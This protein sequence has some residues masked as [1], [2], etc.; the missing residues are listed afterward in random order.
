MKKT[1]SINIGGVIFHIEEDGYEKLKSYL[2]SIQRYFATFSD[3][4]EI[5]SDIEAR[6]AERFYNKQ[7][8]EVKQVISI[9]DVEELIKA[10]GTVADFEAIEQA[11]DILADPLEV[12]AEPTYEP[13]KKEKL[14][15]T[16]ETASEERAR[17]KSNIPRKLYRDLKRKLIGGVAAGLANYF[18]IDAIWVRLAFIIAVAGLPASGMLNLNME[19]AFGPISGFVTLLY[20]AMWIAFP[21]S[22]T[23]EED[24]TIK[25]FYRDPD[26]KVVGGVAAGIASYFGI[27]LGVARFLWVISILFF[28]TGFVAYVVLWVISPTAN[29]L[30]EKMEMQGEPITLSNIESNIKQSLNLDSVPGEENWVSKIMLF[31]FRAIAFIITLLGKLL[32][33]IG[34]VIRVIIG[35]VLVGFSAL[36]LLGIIIAGG[37]A[38]GLTS[39]APFD[40]LP[41]PFLIFQ[42]LPGSLILSAILL[43]SIPLLLFLLLGITLLSNRKVV[44]TSVWL[45][46]AGL[47]IVG[48]IGSII[49]GVTYQRNFAKHGE[50]VVTTGFSI[51]KGTL[52]LETENYSND[53]NSVDV[54]IRLAG[55]EASDSLK[56]EKKL[57]SRGRSQEDAERNAQKLQYKLNIKDSVLTF[58]TDPE[59]SKFSF[60][61]NQRIDA[62]LNIPYNKPFIMSRDFYFASS[63]WGDGYQNIGRYDLDNNDINWKSLRWVMLRDSGLICANMPQRFLKT[64]SN[65]DENAAAYRYDDDNGDHLELGDRGNYIKQFPV[66]AFSKIDLGGAYAIH[67]QYGEVYEVT[68]DGEEEDVNNIRVVNENGILKVERQDIG[69]FDDKKWNRIGLIIKTPNL[70][71]IEL[72]GAN[73]TKVSGFKGLGRLEV[74][75]SGSSRSEIEVEA[76]KLDIDISGASKAMFRGTAKDVK[77]YL[78]GASKVEARAMQI[79]RAE[80]SAAGASYADMG[81]ISNLK[82]IVTGASKIDNL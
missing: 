66:S 31:P 14:A 37:V 25:K 48:V 47:W 65:E 58:P 2:S 24:T 17:F 76:Q 18:T 23:L 82:K 27:D 80:I 26:R 22:N 29:T 70:E 75:I 19:D 52:T 54:D 45:T 46:M 51:P 1:I 35:A 43:A 59:I 49:G 32:I 50:V 6:I 20:I 41:I 57:Y 60:F 56:L 39:S 40:N 33:G 44:P 69:L 4:K 61:R 42:E 63:H 28:G 13:V 71:K 62:V 7:K 21:G 36:S 38:L 16:F 10:M 55:F 53:N 3:S 5:V 72:S 81:H 79:E 64:E 74:A 8:S 34:P 11:E 15:A 12:N 30:T 68:A 78:S 67:I 77:M 73:K 9:E